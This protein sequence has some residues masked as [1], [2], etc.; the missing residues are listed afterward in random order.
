MIE[1]SRSK[2]TYKKP[3]IKRIDKT[4]IPKLIRR[5]LITELQRRREEQLRKL[6]SSPTWYKD[7]AKKGSY[8]VIKSNGFTFPLDGYYSNSEHLLLRDAGNT[9]RHVISFTIHQN[10]IEIHYIQ[11]VVYPE[12]KKR[13]IAPI[14]LKDKLNL[15][16]SEFLLCELINKYSRLIISGKR[17]ILTLDEISI[18]DY[19]FMILYGPL[20]DRY[21]KRVEYNKD[22]AY[23]LDL[24]KPRVKALL[25]L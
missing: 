21:F 25:G 22:I 7:K 8:S 13:I 20:I 10:D 6:R 9:P 3:E 15:H 12:N 2:Q 16:P 19:H 1:E 18:E 23:E 24:T 4:Q 5:K 14:E 17:V 11:K